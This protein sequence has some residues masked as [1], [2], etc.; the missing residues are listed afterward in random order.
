MKHIAGLQA[1]FMTLATC[2]E[3]AQAQQP[4]KIPRIGYVSGTGN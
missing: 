2:G 3:V 1:I 4:A